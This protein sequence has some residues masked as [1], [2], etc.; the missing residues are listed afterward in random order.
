MSRRSRPAPSAS[1][2]TPT[3]AGGGSYRFDPELGQPVPVP[4]VG[5]PPSDPPAPPPAADDKE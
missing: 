3:P 2:L 4:A 5:V 1:G